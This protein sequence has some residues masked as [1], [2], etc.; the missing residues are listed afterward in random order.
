MTNRASRELPSHLTANAIPSGREFGWRREDFPTVLHSAAAEGWACIGGQFQWVL[1][2]GTFEAYW[3]NADSG[4]RQSGE[5]W[6]AY[7]RRTEKEVSTGYQLL[8]RTT[9]FNTEADK[10]DYLKDK[11]AQ[12]VALDCYLIFVAYFK[13]TDVDA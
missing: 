7:V 1:P 9:D 10:S 13:R 5:T 8:L 11:K 12:G 6:T 2:D 4:P 3:L